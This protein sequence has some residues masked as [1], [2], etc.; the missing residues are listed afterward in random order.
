MLGG[1][2]EWLTPTTLTSLGRRC[3]GRRG[4]FGTR[5]GGG[6]WKLSNTFTCPGRRLGTLLNAPPILL[7][8]PGIIALRS[9]I[10]LNGMSLIRRRCL[11]NHEGTLIRGRRKKSGIIIT[12][13]RRG[14]IH[15]MRWRRRRYLHNHGRGKLPS[16]SCSEKAYGILTYQPSSSVV[17]RFRKE[18]L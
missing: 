5:L 14:I 1:T 8:F 16:V 6:G 10:L 9:I 17:R 11:H 4:R 13:W 15:G 7:E 12:R 3:L 2:T 18:S